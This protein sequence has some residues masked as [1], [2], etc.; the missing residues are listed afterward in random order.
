MLYTIVL[1]AYVLLSVRIYLYISGDPPLYSE[2]S[3]LKFFW[4]RVSI[5]L[6]VLPMFVVYDNTH[7]NLC[8]W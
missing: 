3:E 2:L 4:D 1:V 8:L 5:S 7:C 6:M